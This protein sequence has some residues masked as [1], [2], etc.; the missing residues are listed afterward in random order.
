MEILSKFKEGFWGF[1]WIILLVA[2]INILLFLETKRMNGEISGNLKELEKQGN[3][4]TANKAYSQFTKTIHNFPD[5]YLNFP[6][7]WYAR[8]RMVTPEP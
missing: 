6:S 4:L 8:H 5:D 7:A 2:V 1:D 3:L